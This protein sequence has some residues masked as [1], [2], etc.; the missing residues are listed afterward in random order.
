M[1]SKSILEICSGQLLRLLVSSNIPSQPHSKLS[2][3]IQE[4][5]KGASNTVEWESVDIMQKGALNLR[6]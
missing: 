1:N 3:L 4:G 5:F 2:F 6:Y